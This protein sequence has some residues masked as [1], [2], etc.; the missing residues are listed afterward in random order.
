MSD[1]SRNSNFRADFVNLLCHP[2]RREHG[3]TRWWTIFLAVAAFL[4]AV[5]SVFR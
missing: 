3:T 4:I 1:E 5:G 2:Y